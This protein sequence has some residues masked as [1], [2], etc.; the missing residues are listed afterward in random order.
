MSNRRLSSEAKQDR[1]WL[2]FGWEKRKATELRSMVA[3]GLCLGCVSRWCHTMKT[4]ATTCKTPEVE[5][6]RLT[7]W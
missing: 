4:P 3:S 6:T 7:V 2:V 1:A 5:E